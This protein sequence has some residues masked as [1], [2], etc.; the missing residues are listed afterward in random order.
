MC[1]AYKMCRNTDEAETKRT[2]NQWLPQLEIHPTRERQPLTLLVILCYA[3]RQESSITVSWEASSSSRWKQ[4][5]RPAAKHQTELRTS[6]GRVG[7]RIEPAAWVKNITRRLTESTNLGPQGSRRL[8]PQAGTMQGLDLDIL[9][10]FNKCSAWS[11]CDSPNK[12]SGAVSVSVLFHWIPFSYLDC[13]VGPQWERIHLVLLGL[14]VPEWGGTQVGLPFSEKKG[15]GQWG[16]YL[17][18]WDWEERR[19]GLVFRI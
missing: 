9:H 12:W 11:L 5:E 1:P 19:E 6:W 4:I 14:D 10:I 13:L 8:G 17:Q 16:S 18:G 15:R 7:D 3:C 2:V